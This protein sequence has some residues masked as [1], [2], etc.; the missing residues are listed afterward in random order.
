MSVFQEDQIIQHRTT[1]MKEHEYTEKSN[2]RIADENLSNELKTNSEYR[3]AFFKI[4]C[5]YYFEFVNNGKKL[6]PPESFIKENIN[7]IS[8]NDSIGNFIEDCLIVTKD[9]QNKIRTSVVVKVLKSYDASCNV[10]FETVKKYLE[11]KGIVSKKSNGYPTYFG[12]KFKSYETLKEQI[13]A[14]T[15]NELIEMNLIT[16]EKIQDK[17]SEFL[18][19]DYLN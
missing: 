14:D 13:K 15:I 9:N 18:E 4:L 3:H 10:T 1:F 5:D 17:N 19:D 6:V 11:K 8:Y 12:V 16:G 7:F 2:T